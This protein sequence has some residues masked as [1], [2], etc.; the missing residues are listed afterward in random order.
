LLGHDRTNAALIHSPAAEEIMQRWSVSVSTLLVYLAGCAHSPPP[1][2][3]PAAAPAP[4]AEAPPPSAPKAPPAW[5]AKLPPIIDREIIFG[6]P[7][8]AGAEISPDAK[9]IAFLK[10][11]KGQLNVWVKKRDEPFDAAHPVT[12]D[13]TRP[14]RGFFW[15]RDSKYILFAQ[16]KAGDENFRV[17][18]VDPGAA[19]DAATGAPAARDLTP[20]EKV[21]AQIIA[22]PKRTPGAILI[23]LNDRDPQV[24]DVYRLDLKTGK[25]TLVRKN[26]ENVAGWTAD[27]DGNLRLASRVDKEGNTETL[28]VE[29]DKLVP[30]MSCSVE[31]TCFPY[32]FHKDGKRVYFVTNHGDHD[33]TRLVL[34]DPKN[35]KET[36]VEED[37]EHQVDFGGAG[38]SAATD[39]LVMTSYEADRERVYPKEAK[40]AKD[41]EVVRKALP[42][43]D[44][45]FGAAS[46]DDR[47]HI[48]AV[49]SDVEPGATYLYDRTTG[50]VDLLYRP[51][52][53][54]PAD[55]LAPMKPVRY[56]ARDG[57]EITAYLTVPKGVEAKGLPAV[58]LPHGGPW[59]RDYWG[60]DPIAQFLANRG[61]VVLQPEFRASTGFGKKFLNLGNGQWGTG[62]MQHDITDGAKWL[63]AQ[64]IADA[65]QIAIMGGS[66]GGYAT[67]AGLAFT[68][69]VYA[70][71]VDICGPSSILTLLASLPPYWKP[72]QKIFQ[73]RVGD[74]EQDAARLK[75]QSPLFSATK[76]S[77]PLLV[78]Q[79]AN[80]PRVKKAEADQMVVALRDLGRDVEYLLAPDE[81]HGFAG[82]E[83]RLAMMV[84]VERFLAD[85]L[86]G[87]KQ[88]SVS[89]EIA[90]K[91]ASIT[92]DPK[93]VK[94]AAAPAA[95]AGEGKAGEA[96][97]DG[98][99]LTAGALRYAAHLEAG[100]HKIDAKTEISIKADGDVW[101]VVEKTEGAMGSGTDT[102]SLEK[103]TLLPVKR[104]IDQGSAHVEVAFA[105]GKVAGEIKA[106]GQTIP[107]DAKV[108]GRV[109]S[110]GATL[111]LAL[112]TLPLEPGK[113]WTVKSFDLLGGKERG[114]VVAVD[115]VEDV[116]V[117]GG[118]F[119][120]VRVTL[121]AEDAATPD[122]VWIEKAAPHRV[123][124][125]EESLPA[126]MGSGKATGELLP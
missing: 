76:I 54:L 73:H 122:V 66:Y 75:E 94:L 59:Y 41:Y 92:V 111:Y 118:S 49:T 82:R 98:S 9:Y 101:T 48:V 74:P 40:F 23:G 87:R 65:Q 18:A 84:A 126:Q 32:R 78:V 115:K 2:P 106:Q 120:A 22:V 42:E 91:L 45:G 33:L 124:R 6:D 7:E 119:A 88:D 85:H 44:V 117:A 102:T 38:F 96:K 60:Y 4:V 95:G 37:P 36:L 25:R 100:A 103:A 30:I 116:K 11:Y 64:G 26:S 86:P 80:D 123:L 28:R 39:D 20:Y 81:G 97:F 109:L 77:R 110:N 56:P 83:N 12:A 112:S 72:I 8:Y 21:Q 55:A 89:D 67:L 35:G 15:S 29:K 79:G 24:H 52:P 71:G 114:V 17:Y 5:H 99:K 107:V 46:S 16:D 57:I 58:V 108:T 27:L 43:G 1:A 121:A 47:W 50:K 69:D 19:V 113:S 3:V 104:V 62:T 14:I 93:T 61:Y 13:T 70:A 34:I 105:D 10:V 31:E 68:P 125:W 63:A 53:K 51:Y 90:K